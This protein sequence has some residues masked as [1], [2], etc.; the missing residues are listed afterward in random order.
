VKYHISHTTTY[1]YAEAVSLCHNLVHLR[2]R[3]CPRQVCSRHELLVLP[4]PAALHNRIDYF[5]NPASFFTL[6]EPHR[7]MMLAAQFWVE[8]NS[9]AP[10]LPVTPAWEQVRGQLTE[11]RSPE[12]L[13]A[14]QFVFDSPYV[15]RSEVLSEYAAASF[16]S[17]RSLLEGVLDLTRR[18]HQDFRYD[19]QATTLTTSIEEVMAQRRGVCQDF[20]HLQIGCLR[21]LGLATRYVSGYI[22]TQPPPAAGEGER[23]V[24][25][26]ASHAWLAVYCPGLG[27]YD[28]DPTNNQVP[29]DQHITLAWGRDYDDVSPI[30][31]VI[32]GGG[33]HTMSVAVK[34]APLD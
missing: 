34:V 27:W 22:R 15:Q 13:D 2:P 30:K 5:G 29:G 16:P 8:V 24:G 19:K 9:S 11:D 25:A 4:E 32:L 28:F 3:D 1:D 17:G 20:A 21:S 23:L 6:Q 31:G 7:Q 33:A 26:D 18:V 10:T 12:T 14:Y